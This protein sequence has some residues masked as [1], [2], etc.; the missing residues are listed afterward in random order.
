MLFVQ[1]FAYAFQEGYQS[2]E[3]I[4]SH[5]GTQKG[6][7]TET[8]TDI[9][10]SADGYLYVASISGLLTYDG[11]KFSTY[12]AGEMSGFASNRI[13]NIVDVGKGNVL[14]RSQNNT[15]YLFSD[16]KA[17]LLTNPISDEPILAITIKET[18]DGEI[19]IADQNTVY[20]YEDENIQILS[21]IRSNSPIWDVEWADSTLYVLNTEGLFISKDDKL[22]NIEIP[23]AYGPDLANFARII[24][25]GEYIHL[26]GKG[27]K[28]SLYFD[29]QS[30]L[31]EQSTIFDEEIEVL[32]LSEWDN[33]ETYLLATSKGLFIQNNTE[34]TRFGYTE[35]AL[36]F[37]S[38]FTTREGQFT[39]GEDG[40]WFDNEKIFEPNTY[41]LDAA[42]DEQENLWLTTSKN[43]I[44]QIRK[45]YF[46]NINSDELTNSYAVAKDKAG[47]F[48]AG[49]FDNGLFY[50]DE[51]ATNRLYSGNS[52][53]PNNTIRMIFPLNDGRMLVSLW[54]VPPLIIDENR[55]IQMNEFGPLYGKGTNVVEAF[56]EDEDGTWWLGSIDGLYIK[57]G[58]TFT[59]Y[60]DN[61]GRTLRHVTSIQQSP[62][63]SDLFFT[64]VNDG[65]VILR[66]QKFYFLSKS[67]DERAQ[68]VRDIHISGIDT[69]WVASYNGGLQRYI[70]S[71]ELDKPEI[72]LLREVEGIPAAGYHKMIPDTTGHIW[73][74]S[75]QGLLRVS[76]KELN[77]S[78]DE[79][80]KVTM[81][82]WFDQKDGILNR[83]F[84]GG[85]QSTGFYDTHEKRI[86]FT[87]ISGLVSFNPYELERSRI[88]SENFSLN[89]PEADHIQN[90][91][92][93]KYVIHL[94]S[95]KR[96]TMLEYTHVALS[97]NQTGQIWIKIGDNGQWSL[98]KE[99]GIIHLQDLK[100][101]TTRLI[102]SLGSDM[103][104]ISTIEIKIEPYWFENKLVWLFITLVFIGGVASVYFVRKEQ[105]FVYLGGDNSAEVSQ[106][107]I[108]E[109]SQESEIKDPIQ[110][111]IDHNYQ[112]A[113][114][115]TQIISEDLRMSRSSLYRQWNKKNK[116][117]IL[118][119]ILEIR[120]KHA[121]QYLLES[122]IS[123]ADV[124]ERTGFSS[125]SYF[126]KVFKKKY[127]I[128]PS[129]YK[130][131]ITS[132]LEVSQE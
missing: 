129:E 67:L 107:L 108:N 126:T 56:H 96:N 66:N 77:K 57:R 59:N 98:P 73:I 78:A 116:N 74:S 70:I 46:Q 122:E 113:G 25:T 50:W 115:S 104:V 72:H 36:R 82:K 54:G 13:S 62:Y 86:W 31:I 1:G 93:G 110:L 109:D 32:H 33:P 106:S 127:R 58:S 128:S 101:G 37:E 4:I 40:V 29:E 65:V 91:E 83:E 43:G 92:N 89:V 75:N 51:Y 85:T 84:N 53:L 41:I 7:P 88:I 117:T 132:G 15:L 39:V 81:R 124:A 10:I 63:N 19:I 8:V 52:E 22:I 99:P 45:N 69:L 100:A 35:K 24:R 90:L 61:E 38:I 17:K 44:Y 64:T 68:H 18:I 121:K 79:K 114:L 111:Y 102:L 131:S 105:K 119:Y 42:I 9:E 76:K 103:S 120:L 27:A 49:T 123:I 21:S 20:R 5:F 71:K 14:V 30:W 95:E 47:K 55:I 94:S 97:N 60:I 3:F 130:D 26:I 11:F 112:Y 23:E 48:W 34:L 87:N 2:K 28:V 80:S 125:Q 118:D 16:Q 6:L 12:T